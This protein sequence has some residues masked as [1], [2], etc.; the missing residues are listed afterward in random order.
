MR[1]A[2]GGGGPVL[3][4]LVLPLRPF[5][6]WPLGA[7]VFSRALPSQ[8]LPGPRLDFCRPCLLAGR[9]GRGAARRRRRE[10][11]ALRTA[12]E[13]RSPEAPSEKRGPA[14]AA[15]LFPR[16]AA[17][18]PGVGCE[19]NGASLR[20][21]C[22]LGFSFLEAA[23]WPPAVSPGK[24]LIQTRFLAAVLAARCVPAASQHAR[25]VKFLARYVAATLAKRCSPGA[26]RHA[27]SELP[28]KNAGCEKCTESEPA[29]LR[30]PRE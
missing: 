2:W 4:L 27:W 7:Q 16:T 17:L 26:S 19:D 28:G 18:L 14:R 24:A 10:R 6:L 30:G 25:S 29:R 12:E 21:A 23:S 8:T 9:A 13:L 22:C 3:V 20:A 5:L 15:S 1:L 11:R